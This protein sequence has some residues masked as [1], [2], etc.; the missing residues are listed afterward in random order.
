MFGE[1]IKAQLEQQHHRT[2]EKILN[3]C[4]VRERAQKKAAASEVAR[5]FA[6]AQSQKEEKL[7]Y[8]RQIL[9]E[10][11]QCEERQY[12]ILCRQQI[13]VEQHKKREAL[14]NEA[15]M[16]KQKLTEKRLAIANE[17]YKQRSLRDIDEVRDRMARLHSMEIQK[18]REEIRKMVEWDRAEEIKRESIIHSQRSKLDE[19]FDQKI[20]DAEKTKANAKVVSDMQKQM[21]N[22]RKERQNEQKRAQIA[23]EAK[24]LENI[25]LTYLQ[26]DTQAKIAKKLALHEDLQKQILA[27][28]TRKMKSEQEEENANAY[29]KPLFVYEDKNI[30]REEK[31]ILRRE[32]LDFMNYS[33]K[34]KLDEA[35]LEKQLDK[36][37]EMIVERKREV[38]KERNKS[39][40]ERA[41]K[42]H[43]EVLTSHRL[44]SERKIEQ[45]KRERSELIEHRKLMAQKE[46]EMEESIKME[47]QKRF[48][49][50][51]T[52]RDALNKQ[53]LEL[54]AM[55]ERRKK[56][57]LDRDKQMIENATKDYQ[58]RLDEALST[59]P[60]HSIIHPW[61]RSYIK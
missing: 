31:E 22:E 28:R 24:E 60:L 19:L 27:T 41:K 51:R 1:L 18:D 39:K 10:F 59:N 4:K 30:S 35:C 54:Q 12:E 9:F 16:I 43:E 25:K 11:M 49:A 5:R 57:E 21:A 38:I 45:Q 14:I 23:E 58:D 32:Q 46:K 15:E 55:Q 44:E 42:L 20:V 7:Q 26:D 53:R 50:G 56:D 33:N 34:L 29:N 2:Q 47:E 13:E 6:K 3:D 52:S 17:K 40:L 37:Y 36:Q 48:I 61:R 8:R